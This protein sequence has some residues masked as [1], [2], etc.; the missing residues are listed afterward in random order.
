MPT[1]TNVHD[2][3]DVWGR[4]HPP[5]Q[6]AKRASHTVDGHLATPIHFR[7]CKA[8]PRDACARAA[9]KWLGTRSRLWD[10]LT[11]TVPTRNSMHNSYAIVSAC[12][13]IYRIAPMG[14][15]LCVL[16]CLISTAPI[17]A[18]ET[19]TDNAEQDISGYPPAVYMQVFLAC[20]GDSP[21][22]Q[23]EDLRVDPAP[24]GCCVLTVT[25]GDGRGTDEVSSYEVFLNGQRVLPLGRSRNAQAAVKVIKGNTL[26]V[27]LIG[28]PHS[29]V[30]ILVAYDPRESK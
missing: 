5:V 1:V 26:K 27:I 23:T 17:R 30:F 6:R 15:V 7:L 14:F 8:F 9:H 4:A 29:K 25:N 18:Q 16:V 10:R 13:L 28:G 12:I 24:K 20:P 19:K 22:T 11:A 21:C 3:C 2:P